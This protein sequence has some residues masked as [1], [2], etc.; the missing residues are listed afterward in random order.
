M[1][2]LDNFRRCL[3]DQIGYRLDISEKDLVEALEDTGRD[4]IYNYLIFEK[5]VSFEIFCRNLKIY[6]NIQNKET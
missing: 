6:L 1:I 5:D 4:I 2:M 3:E